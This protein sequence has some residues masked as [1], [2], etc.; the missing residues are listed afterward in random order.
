MHFTTGVA[1]PIVAVLTALQ[2][3][4]A[5]IV[6]KIAGKTAAAV[7]GGVAKG[8]AKHKITSGSVMA[9]TT[10]GTFGCTVDSNCG[11]R[12]AAR[13]E[14]SFVRAKRADI[15]APRQGDR[16]DPPEGI[17]QHDWDNCLDHFS[18]VTV[19][20]TGPTGDEHDG[21]EVRPIPSICMPLISWFIGNPTD[22]D[23]DIIPV[24]CDV[25]CVRYVNA[26]EEEFNWV[27]EVFEALTA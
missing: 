21:I 27:K 5:P 18:D 6:G 3:T 12:P 2:G 10:I 4:N 26:N 22:P 13:D 23:S 25:D 19:E 20:I 15:L 14:P 11:R 17:N 16:P 9:V 1:I 8:A 7:A 24:T